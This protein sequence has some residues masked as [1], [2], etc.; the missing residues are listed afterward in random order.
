MS[1]LLSTHFTEFTG[2]VQKITIDKKRNYTYI[3]N[4]TSS[5]KL[6]QSSGQLD[7]IIDYLT[8]NGFIMDNENSQ[9]I[10]FTNPL[11][12]TTSYYYYPSDNRMVKRVRVL[13]DRIR[14]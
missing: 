2:N 8:H 12:P 5:Y 14:V 7:H 3:Y 10:R 13:I 1:Y 4:D 11:E 9:E 6:L